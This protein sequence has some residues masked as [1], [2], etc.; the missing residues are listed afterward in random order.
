ME[1]QRNRSSRSSL[2]SV[3]CLNHTSTSAV[4]SLNFFSAETS[5]RQPQV[6]SQHQVDMSSYFLNSPFPCNAHDICCWRPVT[7]GRLLQ[8]R[9]LSFDW[10]DSSPKLTYFK[11]RK[12]PRLHRNVFLKTTSSV[13]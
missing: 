2:R 13:P 10:T 5:C 1:V 4:S 11:T 12:L 8:L 3:F 6:V 9:C 7:G